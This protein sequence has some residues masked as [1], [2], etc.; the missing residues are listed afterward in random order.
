MT[1][2]DFRTGIVVIT[3][4]CDKSGKHT[5]GVRLRATASGSRTLTEVQRLA[6]VLLYRGFCFIGDAPQYGTVAVHM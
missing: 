2:V 4:G 6:A 5:S 1:S 3:Q